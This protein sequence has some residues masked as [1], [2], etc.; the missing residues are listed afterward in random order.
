MIPECPLVAIE[1]P[2]QIHAQNTLPFSIISTLPASQK[3]HSHFTT[4]TSVPL[5]LSPDPFDHPVMGDVC[6]TNDILMK[7]TKFTSQTGIV[8]YKYE[9][10]GRINKT[11]RY[12][13]LCD[14]QFSP[15]SSDK[16]AIIRRQISNLDSDLMNAEFP[17]KDSTCA[18]APPYFSRGRGDERYRYLQNARIAKNQK[19]ESGSID[20][21][22]FK[23][24]GRE[25]LQVFDSSSKTVPQHST[26][27]PLELDSIQQPG[28][29][30][31]T[32]QSENISNL[33]TRLR[34]FFDS[35]PI[36]TRLALSNT[37]ELENIQKNPQVHTSHTELTSALL[38]VA[39]SANEGPW[40]RVWIKFGVD[41][42]SNKSFKVFQTIDLRLNTTKARIDEE[43]ENEGTNVHPTN[44]KAR[45]GTHLFDGETYNGFCNIYQLCDITDLS[46]RKPINS[47]IGTSHLYTDR[48]GWILEETLTGIRETLKAKIKAFA[49]ILKPSDKAKK[50]RRG[51]IAELVD[52]DMTDSE[53]LDHS[54]DGMYHALGE[55]ER[56]VVDPIGEL[57]FKQQVE[58]LMKNYSEN[59]GNT[60]NLDE[61]AEE[62]SDF[63]LF[64]D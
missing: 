24:R 62:M 43:V 48:F 56:G 17:L 22:P 1:Y 20:V 16:L 49:G 41:P 13:E 39:Y 50:R 6:N 30:S 10:I 12:R 53:M 51:V 11:V 15:P 44:H 27:Q 29:E 21:F 2:G 3:I 7:C 23:R 34:E 38:H 64:D 14:F 47:V 36:W 5:K 63:D 46:L 59:I 18:M 58:V 35:R 40:R 31:S 52:D 55:S 28:F 4:G 9:T 33:V 26:E 45:Y 60:L 32:R 37:I 42:R 57:E 54:D 25:T 61:D 19:K 8:T